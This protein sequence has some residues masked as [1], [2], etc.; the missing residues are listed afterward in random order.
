MKG[1]KENELKVEKKIEVRLMNKP[2]YL[3]DYYKT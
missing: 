2:Q 1:R 3:K